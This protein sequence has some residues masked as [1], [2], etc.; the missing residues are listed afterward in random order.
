[1]KR[2]ALA[3]AAL[4][5]CSSPATGYRAGPTATTSTITTATQP[6]EGAG[7]AG[8]SPDA[9]DRRP[10]PSGPTLAPSPPATT[11][12]PTSSAVPQP[13]A[14]ATASVSWYGAESG[15]HTA[16]GDAYDPEGLTFAHRTLPFGTRV[17]FTGPLGSVV[18]VATD[19]GPAAWTG[20]DFDLSRGAF[21][22]LAPLSSG[23]ATVTWA[24][25]G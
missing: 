24:V 6:S 12:P 18:A 21:A 9:G 15:A 4:A 8:M 25:V 2:A 16:N 5:A 1:M 20:R 22:R 23:V 7:A 14:G 19:R 17:L 13:V 11:E 3:L 10:A